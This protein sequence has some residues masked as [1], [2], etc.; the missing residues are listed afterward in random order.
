LRARHYADNWGYYLYPQDGTVLPPA[1]LKDQWR[2]QKNKQL[3]YK[4]P[5]HDRRNTGYCVWEL[6]ESPNSDLG[7][8]RWFGEEVFQAEG[9]IMC[10]AW[11][12]EN[13]AYSDNKSSSG[14]YRK[15][16]SVVHFF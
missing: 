10:Q 5:C 15:C 2:I 1:D 16:K 11:S 7:S 12:Q 13:V 8:R 4:S 9:K 6:W 14:L 3:P